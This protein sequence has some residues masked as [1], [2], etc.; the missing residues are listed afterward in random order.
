MPEVCDQG[1]TLTQGYWKTHAIYAAK[2]QFAKKRD[3]TWDMVMPNA[4]ATTFYKS[5]ASWITVFWTPPKGNA[6]YNL[7]HQFMAA[8]L[9]G[10]AGAGVPAAVAQAMADADGWFTLHAPSASFWKNNKT[11]VN[12]AAGLLGS[13]NEGDLGP[14]HCDESVQRLMIMAK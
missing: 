4:E 12:A 11:T 8:K 3:I 7:A 9:N 14:G 2:P 1:C 6:Y 5:G 10:Y 13:Y